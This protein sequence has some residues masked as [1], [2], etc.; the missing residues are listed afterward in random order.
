MYMYEAPTST[1]W[2]TGRLRRRLLTC[3]HHTPPVQLK[4]TGSSTLLHWYLGEPPFTVTLKSL[5]VTPEHGAAALHWIRATRSDVIV[6]AAGPQVTFLIA[7]VDVSQPPVAPEKDVHCVTWTGC[8]STPSSV[9][10]RQTAKGVGEAQNTNL[11]GIYTPM[12]LTTTLIN[13][14]FG[15]PNG[16]K[17]P[18]TYVHYL[19]LLHLAGSLAEFR[20]KFWRN[21]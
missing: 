1:V 4:P 21:P 8:C 11:N 12:L 6:P 10:L 14:L 15:K 3:T 17:K 18:I 13:V 5:M 16:N 7:N 20:S 2:Q 19:L 9:K